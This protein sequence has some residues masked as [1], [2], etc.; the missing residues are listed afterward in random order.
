[1][2]NTACGEA[3]AQSMKS[4]KSQLPQMNAGTLGSLRTKVPDSSMKVNKTPQ[5]PLVVR[6]SR[7]SARALRSP[8]KIATEYDRLGWNSSLLLVSWLIHLER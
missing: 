1:M 8:T 5:L 4:A 2:E 3:N 6:Q 7:S